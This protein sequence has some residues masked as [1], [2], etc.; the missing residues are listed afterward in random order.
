MLFMSSSGLGCGASP[1]FNTYKPFRAVYFA[2]LSY[3][4]V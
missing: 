4:P 1:V 3:Y 2:M